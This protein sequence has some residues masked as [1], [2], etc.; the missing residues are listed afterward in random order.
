MGYARIELGGHASKA[1]SGDSQPGACAEG[2]RVMMP[3]ELQ[4]GRRWGMRALPS[5]ARRMAAARINLVF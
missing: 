1:I 2:V 3:T 4:L 5:A